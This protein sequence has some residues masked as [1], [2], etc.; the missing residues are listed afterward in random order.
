[1][2][3]YLHYWFKSIFII[4]LVN[5]HPEKAFFFFTQIFVKLYCLWIYPAP[6]CLTLVLRELYCYDLLYLGVSKQRYGSLRWFIPNFLNTLLWS[7]YPSVEINYHSDVCL[8]QQLRKM[9]LGLDLVFWLWTLKR[10][11]G[12]MGGGYGLRM[13]LG[14]SKKGIS[15]PI[16]YWQ[17]TQSD[18]HKTYPHTLETQS[19]SR[20]ILANF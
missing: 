20:S 10:Q 7:R 1:M 8:D 15:F 12:L 18:P 17:K 5:N 4:I 6:C 2:P 11:M 14:N 16:N 19:R 3:W 9:V 13:W